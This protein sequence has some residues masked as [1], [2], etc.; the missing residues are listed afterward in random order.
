MKGSEFSIQEFLGSSSYVEKYKKG[1]MLIVRLAP[2]DYHRFHFPISGTIG[3]TKTIDGNYYSVSPIALKKNLEIFCQNKRTRSVLKTAD[4]GDILMSEVG[5]TMVGSILQTYR[6][7]TMVEKGQ[8]K[9]YFAFG[10]STLV[11]L[12]EKNKIAFSPDLIQ[13][14]NKGFETHVK[15]G[16]TIAEKIN[17]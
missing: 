7:Y 1:A 13:N 5:A 14:T 15:M 12:F 10:G 8:E 4:Y 2:T 17:Q 9:G 11:L 3:E 16:E 6:Q